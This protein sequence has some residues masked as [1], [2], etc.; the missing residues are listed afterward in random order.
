MIFYLWRIDESTYHLPQRVLEVEVDQGYVR[1]LDA[2]EPA[3][4]A[5]VKA[6]ASRPALAVV[7]EEPVNRPGGLEHRLVE[8]EVGHGDP[9]YPLALARAIALAHGL[10]L[11][12][13]PDFA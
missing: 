4:E 9:A 11:T 7:E 2:V 8:R 6:I 1:V 12:F 13:T 10:R 5:E 3:L